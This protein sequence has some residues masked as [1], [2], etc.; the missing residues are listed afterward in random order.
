MRETLVDYLAVQKGYQITDEGKNL[1]RPDNSIVAKLVDD[2]RWVAQP[3]QEEMTKYSIDCGRGLPSLVPEYDLT[4]FRSHNGWRY[5][6]NS[7]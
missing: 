7:L 1:R 2:N 5:L 6:R 3:T 4:N